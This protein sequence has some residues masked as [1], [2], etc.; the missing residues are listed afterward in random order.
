MRRTLPVI[1]ATWSALAVAAA[2]TYCTSGTTPIPDGASSV[3][4]TFAVALPA[5]AVVTNVTVSVSAQ[6]PWVGDLSLVLRDPSGLDVAILDRPGIPSLGFPG[7]WGCGGDNLNATFVDGAPDAESMCSTTAVP[8]IAG[9]VSP[10]QPLSSFVGRPAAGTWTL[11]ASDAAAFDAGT[12]GTVCLTIEY[13]TACLGDL[14]GDGQVDGADLGQLLGAW[15]PCT[16]CNAD[17]TGDGVIDG[18]DL[19]IVLGAWGSC[20]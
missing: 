9:N 6:H 13:G 17:L 11:T 3:A 20:D 10:L 7:P 14:S 19:A 4:R 1:V 2:D 18:G 5:N 12:L 15:G 8:V 16:G